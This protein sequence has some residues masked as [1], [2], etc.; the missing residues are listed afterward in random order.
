MAPQPALMFVPSGLSPMTVTAAPSRSKTAGAD[1][2]HRA[3][4]TVHDDA[5]T[6]ERPA[7]ALADELDVALAEA[8][9]ASVTEPAGA[10]PSTSSRSA[11]I[12]SSSD[13][14]A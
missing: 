13:P 7:E 6:V 14:P 9:D 10:A 1:V 2:D 5:E 4:G 12:A 3:V 8:R 11:S